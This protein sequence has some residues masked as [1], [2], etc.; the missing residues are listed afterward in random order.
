M[1]IEKMKSLKKGDCVIWRDYDCCYSKFK[2]PTQG[3]VKEVNTKWITVVWADEWYDKIGYV[4]A[5]H[6]ERVEDG[7][8]SKPDGLFPE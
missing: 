3:I 8:S 1:T 5:H 4:D 7:P 2:E 6:L